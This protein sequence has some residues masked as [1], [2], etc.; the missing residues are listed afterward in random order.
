MKT[1]IVAALCLGNA[2][3][4]DTRLLKIHMAPER[5]DRWPL[6]LAAVTS[7]GPL[8]GAEPDQAL[9]LGWAHGALVAA[10]PGDITMATLVSRSTM[11]L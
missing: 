4:N 6:R 2:T 11:D 8:T 1:S 7:R 9:R 10:Y 5:N 3:S